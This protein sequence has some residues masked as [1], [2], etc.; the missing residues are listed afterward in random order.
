MFQERQSAEVEEKK[1]VET[2]SGGK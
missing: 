1:K 2:Q